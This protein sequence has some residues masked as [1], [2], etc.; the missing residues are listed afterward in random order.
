MII[1]CGYYYYSFFCAETNC[2]WSLNNAES[3]FIHTPNFPD[4]YPPGITCEWYMDTVENHTMFFLIPKLSL[5]LTAPCSDYLVIRES[6]SPYSVHTYQTCE[7]NPDPIVIVARTKKL[8]IKFHS[9]SLQ[10]AMGFKMRFATYKGKLI[11]LCL[12]K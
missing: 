11:K 6:S 9:G 8:Y 1:S 2:G 7:S 3:G 10:G 4:P 5:P 12:I